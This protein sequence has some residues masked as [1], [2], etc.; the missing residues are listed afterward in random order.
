MEIVMKNIPVGSDND[1]N[2]PWNER[3][4]DFECDE[5]GVPINK[6]GLCGSK[7]CLEASMI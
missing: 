5:C 6:E 1:P 7:H 4:E 2:A 3:E